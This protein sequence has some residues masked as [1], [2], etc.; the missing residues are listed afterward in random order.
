MN[1]MDSPWKLREDE[2]GEYYF[3]YI[4]NVILENPID[5]IIENQKELESIVHNITEE[6]WLYRYQPEKWSLGEVVL[7]ILDTERVFMYRALRSARH[8]TTPM[9]G[10]DQDEFIKHYGGNLERHQIIE[11][12]AAQKRAT[13]ST[14]IGLNKQELDFVGS[15]SGF[16]LSARAAA[17]ILAGH[18]MHHLGVIRERYLSE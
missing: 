4:E 5:Q 15:A 8:D 6:D 10:Y 13:I 18:E 7:H 16:P 1:Y 11:E 12:Y 9:P 14:L 17:W 2:Y 3:R